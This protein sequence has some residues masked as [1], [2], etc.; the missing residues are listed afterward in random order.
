M[1]RIAVFGLTSSLFTSLSWSSSA[2]A[3]KAAVKGWGLFFCSHL[4]K[5]S[6]T[7]L[8]LTQLLSCAVKGGEKKS[9]GLSLDVH[10]SSP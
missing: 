3:N 6:G 4:H 10:K 2:I 7:R 5:P 8:H 9:S 1:G